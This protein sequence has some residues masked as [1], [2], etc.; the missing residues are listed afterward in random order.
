MLDCVDIFDS[1]SAAPTPD[2]WQ[3]CRSSP[4][5]TRQWDN[6]EAESKTDML[7][8]D[9]G[10]TLQFE[11]LNYFR[12]YMR[13]AI[14]LNSSIQ[15]LFKRVKGFHCYTT[16]AALFLEGEN[17]VFDYIIQGR[18]EAVLFFCISRTHVQLL[19]HPRWENRSG[20]LHEVNLD[21][22][23]RSMISSKPIKD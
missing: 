9:T 5:E 4:G 14:Q 19:A 7:C 16:K 17:Q 6:P 21:Y 2:A 23:H 11:A 10:K 13:P 18:Q 20:T 3:Y 12:I 15:F 22:T 1:Q 8:L